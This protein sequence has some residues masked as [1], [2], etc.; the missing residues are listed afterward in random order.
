MVNTS[1]QLAMVNLDQLGGNQSPWPGQN[2]IVQMQANVN[3]QGAFGIDF[4]PDNAQGYFAY[5]VVP[6]DN[7]W[8]F[9]Y[10]TSEGAI[11]STLVSGPLPS[12]MSTQLTV[13]V[14]VEG[15]V[16]SFYIN[17]V[18]TT[19]LAVTGSQYINKIAGLAV[20]ARA[21]ITFS[22]FAIYALP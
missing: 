10:Y 3:S 1:G 20:D 12:S 22:N 8:A 17:G 21:D 2:F 15:T 14:R 4:L 16:Y 5:L 19:G 18:D 9:N 6:P 11:V 7:Y 13:D